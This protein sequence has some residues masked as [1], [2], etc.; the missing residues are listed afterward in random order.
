MPKIYR[1]G[2]LTYP[3]KKKKLFNM[4]LIDEYEK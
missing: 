4:A 1:I 2:Y 3:I